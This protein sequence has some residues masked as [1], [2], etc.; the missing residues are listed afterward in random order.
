MDIE[1]NAAVESWVAALSP[2]QAHVVRA[3]V[4]VLRRDGLAA[5]R[6]WVKPIRSTQQAIYELR[7]PTVDGR[8]L[9]VLFADLEGRAVLL[10]GGDKTDLGNRWYEVAVPRA[11]S[12][13]RRWKEES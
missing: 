8:T 11:E 6:R 4:A 3:A 13:L 5:S 2:A 7:M 1:T 12:A 9:R 10:I